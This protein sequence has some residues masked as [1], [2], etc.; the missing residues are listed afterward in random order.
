[1]KNNYYSI[2]PC[3]NIYE[4]PSINSKIEIKKRLQELKRLK[5]NHLCASLKWK[6]SNYIPLFP[7]S[8]SSSGIGDMLRS[9]L[10]AIN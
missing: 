4:H 6:G 1:M 8:S 7:D 9:I 10:K 5:G 3:I 2:Y